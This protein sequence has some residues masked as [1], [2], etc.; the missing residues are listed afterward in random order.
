[1]VGLLC[2]QADPGERPPMS[3]VVELLRNRDGTRG[4]VG[5]DLGDPP[6]FYVEAGAAGGFGGGEA[7]TLLPRNISEASVVRPSTA[8]LACA[9]GVLHT[10]AKDSQ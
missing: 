8:G 3:R 7:S 6:F 5:L 10:G 1:M 2:A 9:C 4:D